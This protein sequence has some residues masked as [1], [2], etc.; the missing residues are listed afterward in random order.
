M[1]T[2]FPAVAL[3]VPAPGT[4]PKSFFDFHVREVWFEVGFGSG[5]HLIHH[6]LQ[7]PDIGMVGCEPFINGV[8][9]LCKDIKAQGVKNIRIF[10]D[11]ARLF[12]PNIIDGGF[13]RAFVLNSDPWPK[14]RHIKRRF[15]Q[16]ETLDEI[17]RLLKPGAEFR[18]S[19]DHPI[20]AAW[21]LE[22]AY[23]H[24]GFEWL[25]KDAAN[26]RERPADFPQTRYQHKGL[27]QGRPTVFLNFRKA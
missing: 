9:A 17:H 19:S 27:T 13:D 16:K 20:L 21:Q 26:W 6:A 15:I 4:D 22:Q 24:G 12:M 8:A 10:N 7:N 11:D 3:G 25:A 18:M 14:K 2:V 23:F 5:E 1:E